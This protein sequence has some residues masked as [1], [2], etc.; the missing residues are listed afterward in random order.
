[1]PKPNEPMVG[2]VT[3]VYN[4]ARYIAECI[5]SILAQSYENWQCVVCDNAS[6]DGTAEIAEEYARSDPRVRVERND[7]DHVGFLDSWN[8]AMRALPEGAAYCKVIHSD[9]RLHPDCLE[10]MVRLAAEHPSVGVVGAYR[11]S[12]TKVTLDGLPLDETV[13]P[14]RDLCRRLFLGQLPYLFGSPTSTLLRAD[15]VRAREPFYDE[16][17]FHADTVACY[18]L[19]QESDFGFVHEVLTY[20]RLHPEAITSTTR[21][22]GSY[23]PEHLR[24]LVR[25]GPACLSEDEYQ[26]RLVA[27][28]SS[29]GRSLL[30]RPSRWLDPDFRALHRREVERL[31]S[32]VELNEL[33]AGVRTQIDRHTPTLA[34]RPHRSR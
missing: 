16:T 24:M 11:L 15:L 2:V 5:E 18:D 12:G 34:A 32:G 22:L 3:P 33:V 26:R 1:M 9:D 27:L 14:G 7:D 6:T 31:R 30:R 25:F 28:A 4:G 13:V 10:R 21:R 19:L 23:K 29:Y 17:F 8:R 20:T